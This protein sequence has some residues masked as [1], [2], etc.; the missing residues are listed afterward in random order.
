MAI[1]RCSVAAS[2][3]FQGLVRPAYGELWPLHKESRV[4]I[5]SEQPSAYL[6]FRYSHDIL[7]TP[8][9]L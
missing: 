4:L 3:P 7:K 8:L 2:T 6:S 9:N 5:P 1:F